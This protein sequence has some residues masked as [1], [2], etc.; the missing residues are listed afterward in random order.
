MATWWQ[1][2]LGVRNRL[3]RSGYNL[4]YPPTCVVCHVP[5]AGITK[6]ANGSVSSNESSDR[7]AAQLLCQACSRQLFAANRNICLRCAAD[8]DAPAEFK[9]QSCAACKDQVFRFVAATALGSYKDLLRDCVLQTKEPRAEALTRQL[10]NMLADIR[11][12]TIQAWKCDAV[13]PIPMHWWRRL[14]HGANSPDLIA[15]SLAEKLGLPL[16][17]GSL[18]RRKNT[19]SQ[20]DLSPPQRRKNL[21]KAF[22]ISRG[23][24]FGGMRVLLVDDI[25]TTGATCN[26]AARVMLEN[27]AAEIYVATIARAVLS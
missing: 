9:L 2:V 5:L 26:E 23:C 1:K 21:R 11:G 14:Q 8:V 7:C 19:H 24:S 12:E 18:R 25:L 15:E 16:W 10:G 4:I 3:A 22:C 17:S 13:V 27:G 6:P 20:H